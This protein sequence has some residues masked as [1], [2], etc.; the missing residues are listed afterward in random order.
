MGFIIEQTTEMKPYNLEMRSMGYILR[1][2][3]WDAGQYEFDAGSVE[4]AYDN[5]AALR[6]TLDVVEKYMK[7]HNL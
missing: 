3:M 7:E 5:I 4:L 1:G 6:A 2:R